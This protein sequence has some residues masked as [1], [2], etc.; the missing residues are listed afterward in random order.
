MSVLDVI[1]VYRIED[2]SFCLYWSSEKQRVEGIHLMIDFINFVLSLDL[3]HF[4]TSKTTF[5]SFTYLEKTSRTKE[6]AT[7]H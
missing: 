5:L 3:K 4:T 2:K 6:L 7:S 1:E